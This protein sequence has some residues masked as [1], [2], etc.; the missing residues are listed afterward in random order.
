MPEPVLIQLQPVQRH[1]EV[2]PDLN[3]E[4]TA[5]DQSTVTAAQDLESPIP[6]CTADSDIGGDGQ[7][8]LVSPEGGPS[9]SG[10]AN[11]NTLSNDTTTATCKYSLVSHFNWSPNGILQ[12]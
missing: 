3:A 5:H 6:T 9:S 12:P 4:E 7:P 11:A 10:N 8:V 2:R 1:T